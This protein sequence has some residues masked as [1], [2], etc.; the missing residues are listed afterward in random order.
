VFQV[1]IQGPQLARA[2]DLPVVMTVSGQSTPANA[3]LNFR[4]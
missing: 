3:L 4:R 1:N 2:G